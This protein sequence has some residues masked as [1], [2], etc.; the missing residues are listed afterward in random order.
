MKIVAPVK[1]GLDAFPACRGLV[2][3]Y[4]NQEEGLEMAGQ[5][6]LDSKGFNGRRFG[7]E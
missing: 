5:I 1:L 6:A 7:V 2:H 3:T 4:Q